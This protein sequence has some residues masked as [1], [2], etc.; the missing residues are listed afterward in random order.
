MLGQRLYGKK[1]PKSKNTND[2]MGKIFSIHIT[3]IGLCCL[4]DK[5]HLQMSEE[6]TT[7]PTEKWMKDRKRLFL[8]EECTWLLNTQTDP[9]PR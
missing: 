4:I 8:E 9:K 1:H 7:Y 2:N 5:W 3:D 6:K